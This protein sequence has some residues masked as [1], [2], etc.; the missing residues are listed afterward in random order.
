MQLTAGVWVNDA[1][2]GIIAD[3]DQVLR[4]AGAAGKDY[5]HHRT[6]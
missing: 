3:I 6:G 2:P 5:R 1:E 4:N